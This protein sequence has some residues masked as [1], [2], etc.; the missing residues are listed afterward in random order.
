[1]GTFGRARVENELAWR[2]EVPKL[3]AAYEAVGA[4][5]Y[6]ATSRGL[7]WLFGRRA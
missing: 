2:H 6:G 3:L 5:L 4:A 7:P 1:M